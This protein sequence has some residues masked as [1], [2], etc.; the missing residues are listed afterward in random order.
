[1][2]SSRKIT[3]EE[4]AKRVGVSKSAV[5]RA[6]QNK[7]GVSKKTSKQ[8]KVVARSLGYK[9]S[10]A[11]SSLMSTIRSSKELKPTFETIAFVNA[12]K[13]DEKI[14][15]YSAISEYLE[16]A[17]KRASQLGYAIY[18]INLSDKRIT[19]EKLERT[20]LTRN[21]KGG[22]IFGHYHKNSVSENYVNV[23][24]KFKFISMGVKSNAPV[25]NSTFMD[26]FVVVKEYIK[27]IAQQGYRRIGFVIE[28]F[29]DDYEDGKF[30]G[31]YLKAQLDVNCKEIIPPCYWGKNST[32]NKKSF[33]KYFKDYNLDAIFS[34][35]TDISDVLVKLKDIPDSLK[36]FHYDRRFSDSQIARIAN[37][38]KVGIL[39]IDILTEMLLINRAGGKHSKILETTIAPNIVDV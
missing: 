25:I 6:L 16:A 18:D 12:K 38:K 19:P 27:K 28:K 4:I 39:A 35:S 34:Y 37:Q 13:I 24:K 30:V 23:L 11:I 14:W 10:I 15:K 22:V 1:M 7:K 21:I 26:R 20:L 9:S 32:K 5:S 29:A 3:L 8:I 31:G 36:I 2:I 17:K 33:L